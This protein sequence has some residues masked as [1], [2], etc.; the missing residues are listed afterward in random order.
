MTYKYN[1]I[2]VSSESGIKPSKLPEDLCDEKGWALRSG[3]EALLECKVN[4]ETR[5]GLIKIAET[6]GKTRKSAPSNFERTITDFPRFEFIKWRANLP[7]TQQ[8]SLSA[9][10]KLHKEDLS[11]RR[12]KSAQRNFPNLQISDVSSG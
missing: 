8:N 11:L 4:D 5:F 12:L 7:I 3:I 9:A 6:V 2:N 1:Y 10:Y